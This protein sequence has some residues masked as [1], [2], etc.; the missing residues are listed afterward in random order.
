MEKFAL[1]GMR[2]ECLK[3]VQCFGFP[4]KKSKCSSL[5]VFDVLRRNLCF[6]KKRSVTQLD[7]T[8]L[9]SYLLPSIHI[10]DHF[11]LL[12]LEVCELR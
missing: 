5:E 6:G 10:C 4:E 7:V 3:T 2:H 12:T 1:N 11:F 8:L 9:E